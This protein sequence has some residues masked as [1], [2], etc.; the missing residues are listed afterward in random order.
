[1]P[2][3]QVATPVPPQSQEPASFPSRLGTGRTLLL[4]TVMSLA[5][6]A[7]GLYLYDLKFAQKLLVFDMS[8]FLNEQRALLVAGKTEE[9]ERR[10]N[11]LEA[12]LNNLPVNHVVLLKSVAVRNAAEIKP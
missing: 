2:D 6:T 10:F 11:E 5:L 1:M 12:R 3:Q 4:A 7:A 8:A 9:S